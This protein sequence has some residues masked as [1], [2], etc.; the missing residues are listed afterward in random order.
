M[1]HP[2]GDAGGNGGPSG[3]R[4]KVAEWNDPTETRFRSCHYSM[5][6]HTSLR[7]KAR[8]LTMAWKALQGLL[9][10][11]PSPLSSA[12]IASS[13]TGSFLFLE[14]TNRSHLWAF[15]P[16]DP[17]ARKK[18]PWQLCSY[19]CYLGLCSNVTIREAFPD[20]L[21][22][23]PL[24]PCYYPSLSPYFFSV[25]L[26]TAFIHWFIHSCLSPFRRARGLYWILCCIS[27]TQHSG[28][29]GGSPNR[30]VEYMEKRGY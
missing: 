12:P 11:L 13:F 26:I 1:T 3:G 7:G 15:V 2:E 5:T 14:N 20:L 30:F 21:K 25:L 6:T 19:S 18:S 23:Q 17:Y 27:R 22:E 9:R 10:A 8:G 28:W 24:P 16:A 29:H 4:Q